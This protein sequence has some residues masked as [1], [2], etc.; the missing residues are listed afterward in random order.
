MPM[1]T[2]RNARKYE[3]SNLWHDVGIW[4][5]TAGLVTLAISVLLC[6]CIAHRRKKA[7]KPPIWGTAWATKVSTKQP[8]VERAKPT[9]AEPRVGSA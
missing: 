2:S 6:C 9:T 5:V 3:C 7:R 1:C 4:L 8:Q